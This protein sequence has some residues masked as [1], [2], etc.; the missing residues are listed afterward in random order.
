MHIFKV[1]SKHGW[2]K[3]QTCAD[4][5]FAVPTN[6]I[7]W[8][9]LIH[10]W[11]GCLQHCLQRKGQWKGRF[12]FSNVC[13]SPNNAGSGQAC[14]L[15]WPKHVSPVP[16][17]MFPWHARPNIIKEAWKSVEQKRLGNMLKTFFT[18]FWTFSSLWGSPSLWQCSPVFQTR[19]YKKTS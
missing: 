2:W 18:V 19:D 6:L 5:V 12:N 13:P 4:S 16:T 14:S 17:P 10:F 9:I 3:L 8:M 7:Q 11:W 1:L 15:F